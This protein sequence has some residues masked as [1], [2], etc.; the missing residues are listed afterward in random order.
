MTSLDLLLL[1]AGRLVCAR[2]YVCRSRVHQSGA[3]EQEADRRRR[4]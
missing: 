2:V 1:G 3:G 4:R